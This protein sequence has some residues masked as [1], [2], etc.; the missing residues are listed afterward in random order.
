MGSFQRLTTGRP[1][2][3]KSDGYVHKKLSSLENYLT[4]ELY[5]EQTRFE[6]HEYNSVPLPSTYMVSPLIDGNQIIQGSHES[7]QEMQLEAQNR[8]FMHARKLKQ[9]IGM[10]QSTRLSKF[11]GRVSGGPFHSLGCILLHMF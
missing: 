6:E 4:S 8:S 10:G 3:S 11:S 1:F 5:Q 7:R 9:Y 2:K